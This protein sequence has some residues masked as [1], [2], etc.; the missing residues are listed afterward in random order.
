MV[1]RRSHWFVHAESGS[2]SV[3]LLQYV[4]PRWADGE[5]GVDQADVGIGLREV[6]ELDTGIRH[7]VL[8][9]EPEAVGT[10]EDLIHD[11]L[12]FSLA[13]EFCER[14]NNPE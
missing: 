5:R 9:K 4:A 3:P 7:K 11:L 6:P 14:L 13:T 10:R 12:G 2:Q 1:R 8:G